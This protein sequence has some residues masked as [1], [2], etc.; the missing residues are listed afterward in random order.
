MDAGD[1]REGARDFG[2]LSDLLTEDQSHMMKPR[3]KT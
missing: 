1:H 3:K 2:D